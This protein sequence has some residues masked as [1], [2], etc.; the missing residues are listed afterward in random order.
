MFPY[1]EEENTW[2]SKRIIRKKIKKGNLFYSLVTALL[3]ALFSTT[4]SP[5]A[6]KTSGVDAVI[7]VSNAGTIKSII[8]LS[9]LLFY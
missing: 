8:K 6:A 4:I 3:V 7:I 9:C 5:T 1:T 2:I